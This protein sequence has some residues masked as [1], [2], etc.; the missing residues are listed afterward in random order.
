MRFS[1]VIPTY[2]RAHLLSHAIQSVIGQTLLD[3]ELIVVDDGSTDNTREVVMS[4][5]DM[6]ITY[7]YQ[8][9][10]ERS[11]AR[12]CGIA[13]A[14]GDYI[15]FLDSD[16]YF[17]P[18]R[19]ELIW[20]SLYDFKFKEKFTYTGLL[21]ENN[22]VFNEVNIQ[23]NT[24]SVFDNI[25]TSVIHSQQVCI[26]RDLFSTNRF[27]TEIRIGEDTELWLRIA[28]FH[29]PVYLAKQATVVV[30]DHQDRSVALR[31]NS[32]TESLNTLRYIFNAEHSG[33]LISS[34]VK[35]ARISGC[36]MQIAYYHI[37]RKRKFFAIW[38]LL[39]AM[40][41]YPGSPQTK[42]RINILLKLA[43]GETWDSLW[44]FLNIE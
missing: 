43:I 24:E 20:Q 14:K 12:N 25:V 42:F 4:F 17:L 9:N 8:S 31:K 19:L 21:I 6:R 38:Y 39:R 27:N 28:R 44:K 32:A 41:V 7:I 22:G 37:I 18:Q 36:Y 10:A 15:C 16:D 29:T 13:H 2:N 23:P 11:A 33:S 34:S 30:V 5:E 3:W 26:A 40:L 1:I 35:N